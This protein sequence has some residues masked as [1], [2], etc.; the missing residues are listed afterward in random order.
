MRAC[1][2]GLNWVYGEPAL[3][4]SCSCVIYAGFVTLQAYEAF[5]GPGLLPAGLSSTCYIG[6]NSSITDRL[7]FCYPIASSAARFYFLLEAFS[8]CGRNGHEQ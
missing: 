4:F 8:D 5:G 3:P 7:P 6:S 2:A 1:E